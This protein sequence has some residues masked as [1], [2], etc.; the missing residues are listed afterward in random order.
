M[1]IVADSLIC[2]GICMTVLHIDIN[3]ALLHS[4]QAGGYTQ[5]NIQTQNYNLKYRKHNLTFQPN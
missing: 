1:M 4:S 3:D 2:Q 5:I